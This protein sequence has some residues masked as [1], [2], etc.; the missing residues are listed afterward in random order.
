MITLL[1]NS[2]R[3]VQ[4]VPLQFRRYLL[5]KIDFNNR[6][7]GIKGAR[8]TGKTT[9]LL[10]RL[11][12]L[13]KAA[14]EAAYFPLDD[15]YFLTNTLIDTA[16]QF[17]QQGGKLLLLDEVHKYPRWSQEIKLIYDNYHDL[18]VVF[19]GSSIID[20]SKQEGDLSRRALMYELHGLSYREYLM[21][22]GIADL[23]TLSLNQ[24]TDKKTG[25]RNG[26]D[27]HFRPLVHF[28]DY[29][30]FGYYPFYQE[31]KEGYH[32][33]LRQLARI[34]VEFD[35][36]EIKG[37][38][39]RNA[40]KM[41]QLLYI[42]AVQVPFKPNLVALSEKTSIHRNSISNYL[43][44]L[45]EARL[46]SLL[47]PS[48]SSIATLQKPEKVFL[49]NTNMMY[50]FAEGTPQTGS[51]R[52]TFVNN[53]LKV[54]HHLTMPKTADFEIDGK[55]IFEVGGSGKG[56]KQI[57]GLPNAFVIKDNIEYPVANAIPLWM[58]GM[59]Y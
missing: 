51:I 14:S 8:G 38:D 6:L 55:L 13:G 39:I 54:L 2:D 18:Q 19:T 9:L 10:Q 25:I 42:I 21:M 11:R 7:I 28:D 24:I 15:L 29:L 57:S 3:I 30:R 35:M 36:A 59:L 31:D 48:G 52:E 46:V 49:N 23:P 20:I 33:R 17:Y 44:F 37:F 41:L 12:D 34:I 45:E 58:M 26:F 1:E 4:R 5:S 16:K 27:D 43:Y 32:Q 22:N 47:Y 53:Q 50:A 56:L 40:K